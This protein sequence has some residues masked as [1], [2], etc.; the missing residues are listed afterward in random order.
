MGVRCEIVSFPAF[1]HIHAV[2]IREYNVRSLVRGL[3]LL[4]ALN[5]RGTATLTEL[6]AD[7]GLPKA[8]AF[9]LLQTLCAQQFVCRDDD[10]DQYR[11]A[12]R[13]CSLSSGFEDDAW[14][15]E[16]ARKHLSQLGDRL[17]WPLSLTTLAETRVLVR[18]NTDSRS[19]LV[20]RRLAPGMT[21]PIL[22]SASGKVMLAFSSPEHQQRILESLQRSVMPADRLARHAGRVNTMLGRVR[23]LGYAT[24]VV[25]RRVADLRTLAVPILLGERA[26]AALAIRFAVTAVPQREERE[27]FLPALRRSA[28][29]MGNEIQRD[30]RA[31]R[32]FGV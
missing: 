28:A 26:I 5:A 3:D 29:M 7:T 20:V 13:A 6:C 27:I 15:E 18:I 12:A 23:K 4:T 24:Q 17:A 32:V 22:E 14:L 11:P 25:A 9:R 16:H 1:L 21:L 10:T 31:S 19:P 8:T 30:A 2:A